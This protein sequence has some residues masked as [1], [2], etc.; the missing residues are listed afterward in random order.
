MKTSIREMDVLLFLIMTSRPIYWD[1]AGNYVEISRATLDRM[2]LGQVLAHME[3][4]YF[5]C[6]PKDRLEFS[7]LNR[8]DR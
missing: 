4:D 6:D 1:V 8:V 3:E 5:Y 2:P 7:I